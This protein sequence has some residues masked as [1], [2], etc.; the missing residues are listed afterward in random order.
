MNSL[1]ATKSSGGIMPDQSWEVVD[2]IAG[3]LQAEL[4]R[5]LLEAHNIPVYLSQEGIGRSVYHVI[6]GPMAKVQ[7]LVL[8]P[9][10]QQARQI[11]DE[12]YAGDFEA[13]EGTFDDSAEENDENGDLHTV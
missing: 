3:D 2:N 6:V 10:V 7:I 9:F 5:G 8:G 4:L 11:L 12:Y 13:N 1:I